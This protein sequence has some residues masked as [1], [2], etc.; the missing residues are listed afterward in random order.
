MGSHNFCWQSWQWNWAF[1]GFWWGNYKMSVN[2]WNTECD[3][4]SNPAMFPQ[5]NTGRSFPSKI[6]QR[7]LQKSRIHSQGLASL[8]LNHASI[9][10]FFLSS[11]Y[12]RN[13][14]ST[15]KA[16]ISYLASN[17]HWSVNHGWKNL[18]I[19]IPAHENSSHHMKCYLR[20]DQ[21]EDELQ[22]GISM[23][24]PVTC[25]IKS[26]IQQWKEIL[27]RILN[28]TLSSI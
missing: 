6:F 27:H 9:I 8:E 17:S 5:D 28:V 18:C 10:L 25:I 20:G 14:Y 24:N 4:L 11:F 16:Q 19:R 26:K 13:I 12:W 1:K 22:C 15:S 21:E 2:K 3:P 23:F 7:Y